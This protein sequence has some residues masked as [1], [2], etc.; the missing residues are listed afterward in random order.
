MGKE[1]KALGI[2]TTRYFTK[3]CTK[4]DFEYP[5]WFTNCPKCGAAWDDTEVISTLKEA[6]KKTIKIVVKITEENFNKNIINVNLIFSAD[7]G[8]SWYQMNMDAKTDYYIAEI[9][10]VPV[11]SVIIYY[12]EVCLENGER[13]IENNDEKYFFYKVGVP[14]GESEKEPPKKESKVIRE[15][16]KEAPIRPKTYYKTPMETLKQKMDITREM[17]EQSTFIPLGQSKPLE[18]KSSQEYFSNNSTLFGKPQTKIDPELKVCIHCNSK[19]KKMW[20]T[21]P[22]CGKNL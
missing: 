22:I 17:V 7:Q 8:K 10:E 5:N 4:C 15:S 18:K 19:I 1:K 21:C 20:S 2:K 3:N 13:I 11:G 14:I 6:H 12:I 9:A 16:I